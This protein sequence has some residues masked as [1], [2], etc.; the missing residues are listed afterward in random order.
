[1]VVKPMDEL[2]ALK[3][4]DDLINFCLSP[5]IEGCYV[6]NNL[7]VN[8]HLDGFVMEKKIDG[9]TY[10]LSV[11]KYSLCVYI[12]RYNSKS[13]EPFFSISNYKKVYLYMVDE[14]Q[15]V[16]KSFK[17]EMQK[18]VEQKTRWEQKVKIYISI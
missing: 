5:F 12:D 10:E 8:K 7:Q 15:H 13:L 4:A 11:Y 6:V 17:Y 2:A 3:T 16:L 18:H 9:C 1:M 14:I